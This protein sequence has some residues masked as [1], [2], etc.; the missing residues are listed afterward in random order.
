MPEKEVSLPIPAPYRD[1]SGTAPVLQDQAL[2][3][4]P[5]YKN[6]LRTL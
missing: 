6:T 1:E 4:I 3:L 2:A 5:L